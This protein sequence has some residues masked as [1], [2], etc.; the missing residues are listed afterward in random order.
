MTEVNQEE[1]EVSKEAPIKEEKKEVVEN[2]TTP[3]S[4]TNN[5]QQIEVPE[6]SLEAMLKAGVH[7]GQK[8][9]R[10]NPKMAKYIFGARNNVHIIDLEKSLELLKR[11]LS[12]LEGIAKKDGIVLIVGTKN[13][14]KQI[15]KI[16]ADQIEMPYVNNRWLGGTFTN[17]NFIKN[18]IK[19]LIN[20]RE[21]L[22][23]GRLKDSTKLERNKLQKKLDRIDSR[24][25]G[26]VRMT[27]LPEAVLVLDVNKD[28][29]AVKE[30]RKVGVK[31]IGLLDTTSNPDLVDYPIPA[32][33]DAV[34]SLKY[35]LGAVVGAFSKK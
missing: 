7:F 8:K 9:S 31:V 32:N 17:F 21:A 1:K 14:A 25:G 22:E 18:R 5:S 33:D 15:V 29:D 24:M 2:K 13:Q 28:I 3:S 27:R 26:L 12:Y 4:S 6:L 19:F 16:A 30:A 11:A 35:I 23:Q 10:W 20:N 34:S